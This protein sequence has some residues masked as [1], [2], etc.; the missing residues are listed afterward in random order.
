MQA[1]L[2]GNAEVVVQLLGKGADVNAHDEVCGGACGACG[3]REE[4][5]EGGKEERAGG[6]ICVSNPCQ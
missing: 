6:S 4:G 3:G 1:T 5:G 2:F